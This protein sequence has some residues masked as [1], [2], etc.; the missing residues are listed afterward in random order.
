M[1][2]TSVLSFPDFTI[3]F[4]VESDAFQGMDWGRFDAESN[5]YSV[6]SKGLS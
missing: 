3:P 6:F 2:T 5:A 1:V 4:V